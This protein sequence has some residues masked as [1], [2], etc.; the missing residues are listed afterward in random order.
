MESLPTLIRRGARRAGNF[1]LDVVF[2][3]YQEYEY[4]PPAA[5]SEVVPPSSSE[6]ATGSPVEGPFD[7]AARAAVEAARIEQAGTPHKQ[8]GVSSDEGHP[9]LDP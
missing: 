3:K 4:I 9:A 8:Y 5:K 6:I 2:G 1:A 7:Y